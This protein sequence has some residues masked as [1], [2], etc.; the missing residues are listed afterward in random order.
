MMEVLNSEMDAKEALVVAANFITSSIRTLIFSPKTPVVEHAISNDDKLN[1]ISLSDV[2]LHDTPDD[3]WIVIYDRVY[4]VTNFFDNVSSF[5][6][7]WGGGFVMC[8]IF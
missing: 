2:A 7:I 4:D 1:Q 5:V 3:C 6:I 8:G